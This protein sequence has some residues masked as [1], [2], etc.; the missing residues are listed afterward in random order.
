MGTKKQGGEDWL[1][2]GFRVVQESLGELP[3]TVP[4]AEG[5]AGQ[6]GGRAGGPSR[7][8]KL[9]PEERSAIAKKAATA[10]WRVDTSSRVDTSK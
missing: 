9:T 5:R 8:S 3:R 2:T 10:R 6:A 1:E 7:A 4:P